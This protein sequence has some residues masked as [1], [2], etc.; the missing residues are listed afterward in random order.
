MQADRHAELAERL[1][2]LVE[3]DSTPLD[4]ELVLAEE[5]G[6]VV[7]SNRSEEPILIRGLPA[8]GQVQAFD[9]LSLLLCLG[10]IFGRLAVLTGLDALEILQVR[11][12]RSQRELVRQEVV[13]GIAIRDIPDLAAASERG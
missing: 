7:P 12:G 10:E 2:R 6:D 13:P 8:Q 4:V 1:D 11:P 9:G 3:A 5:R